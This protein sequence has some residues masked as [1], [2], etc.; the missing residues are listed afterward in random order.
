MRHVNTI[1]DNIGSRHVYQ[2]GSFTVCLKRALP[3]RVS[4]PSSSVLPSLPQ[5]AC[6]WWLWATCWRFLGLS[7]LTCQIKGG[8]RQYLRLFAAKK[9]SH[10]FAQKQHL[11]ATLLL[12]TSTSWPGFRLLVSAQFQETPGLCWW[13]NG[14][15]PDFTTEPETSPSYP[16]TCF[17]PP[18][19]SAPK[20]GFSGHF[21]LLTPPSFSAW[22]P[23]SPLHIH[24]PSL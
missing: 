20:G 15:I 1:V 6:A 17:T 16:S 4:R 3:A 22:P 2:R 19:T 11:K 12:V 13:Q 10:K 23:Q 18:P 7:C 5:L 8:T 24:T 14:F 9:W 21:P